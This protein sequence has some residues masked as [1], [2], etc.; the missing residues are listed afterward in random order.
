MVQ[1]RYQIQFNRFFAMM[2]ELIDEI[3]DS[4]AFNKKITFQKAQAAKG[5]VFHKG[6]WISNEQVNK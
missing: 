1:Q 5:R 4:M 6:K 3:K 2:S